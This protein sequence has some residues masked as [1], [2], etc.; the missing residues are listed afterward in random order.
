MSNRKKYKFYLILLYL[1]L[2][3]LIS[4][5]SKIHDKNF[6]LINLFFVQRKKNIFLIVEQFAN[7]VRGSKEQG[8]CAL[9]AIADSDQD[10]SQYNKNLV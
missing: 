8:I 1:I 9:P 4:F 10:G 3:Y 2:F 6:Q 7:Q 5:I